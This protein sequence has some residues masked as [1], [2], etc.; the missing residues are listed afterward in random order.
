MGA[1]FSSIKFIYETIPDLNVSFV[2]LEYFLFLAFGF[3]D[4]NRKFDFVELLVAL[5]LFS[6]MSRHFLWE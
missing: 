3:L 1:S 5:K 2:A 4:A 6:V